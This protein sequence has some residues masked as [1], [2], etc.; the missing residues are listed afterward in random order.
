M[1]KHLPLQSQ[2]ICL[3]LFAMLSFSIN[4]GIFKYSLQS[5]PMETVIFAGYLFSAVALGAYGFQQKLT[6]LPH[7]KV[8]GLIYGGLF[9][10]EQ[11]LFVYALKHIPIAE[12][13]VVVLSTPV[14]V[15]I[16]SAV[17]LK[18]HLKQREVLAV[19]LGFAGALI[20]T[21]TPLLSG[22]SANSSAIPILAWIAAILNVLAGSSKIIYLRKY[23]QKENPFSLSLIA[24][25]AVTIFYGII[26]KSSPMALPRFDLIILFLGGCIGAA[27]CIAYIRAFQIAKAGLISATQYSQIIWA[28]LM[29]VF[30]FKEH[31]TYAAISGS[32]LILC[33]GYF[34]YLRRP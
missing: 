13:F 8:T 19:L 27:G 29:G 11:T 34:L 33:S 4:D 2:G 16:F 3:A 7:N 17:L 12:L 26:L 14:C 25:L 31:L 1:I 10:I 21:G 24:I 22:I 9:L 28:V 20:V 32:L 23:G 15:V 5:F 6:F 30:I 18:E